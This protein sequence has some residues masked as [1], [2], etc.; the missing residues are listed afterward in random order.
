MDSV[1][2]A[3]HAIRLSRSPYLRNLA[4]WIEDEA[5]IYHLDGEPLSRVKQDGIWL[6]K[7]RFDGISVAIAWWD[8]RVKGGSFGRHNSE[9]L[10][11][12]LQHPDILGL[13]L[14][15]A[16]NSLGFRFMEG[17]KIFGSVFGLIPAINQYKKQH[18]VVSICFNQC[19]GL[20]ALLFGLGHYRIAVDQKTTINLA[21]PE[22]FKLFFG[23]KVEFESIA[24][25][26]LQ[27]VNTNLIHEL[28]TDITSAK[29]RAKSIISI[30]Q[31]QR[32]HLLV[33]NEAQNFTLLNNKRPVAH[34]EDN[35]A[36]LIQLSSDH[37]TELFI[38]Y[39]DR[40]KIFI[41]EIDHCFF[42]IVA[43]PPKNP[44]NM[45]T[46]RALAL[47]HE[48]MRLF[49][50]LQLPLL[51]LLD[52]PGI[53]PRMD[54]NNK[55][56]VDKLLELTEVLIEYPHPKLGIIVG[57][58]FGGAT[59]LGIPKE[60]G[61]VMPYI[62]DQETEVNVMHEA[63]ITELL[64]GSERLLSQWQESQRN[65]GE[66]FEDMIANGALNRVISET[67]IYG[68]VKHHLLTTEDKAEGEINHADVKTS[69][70]SIV[71]NDRSAHD[72][73]EPF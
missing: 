43:N 45:F 58:G 57:R 63:I 17:R 73:V 65:Q 15:L 41:A 59:T 24:S 36:R 1:N 14:I 4:D 55:H 21:G 60:Y 34:S 29:N 49:S 52:T 39:S 66:H 23:K 68:L 20:G 48:A 35:L 64:N 31:L 44:N 13:P 40:L 27:Y 50:H 6:I 3:P 28:S 70:L 7:G 61:G 18:L 56:T 5:H 22:V 33:A 19:L 47:Y 67:E 62:L 53:D 2:L 69:P 72:L 32:Q 71:P 38:G 10:R 37:A 9:A 8:F 30:C 16:V 42:G 54:N 51:V 12:F 25:S 46:Y 26:R 11:A